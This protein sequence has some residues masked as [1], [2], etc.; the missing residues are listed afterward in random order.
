[1]ATHRHAWSRQI[2]QN[3]IDNG[4]LWPDYTVLVYWECYC[5]AHA[6]HTHTF[7]PPVESVQLEADSEQ[8]PDDACICATCRTHVNDDGTRPEE[9]SVIWPTWWEL[10]L[11]SDAPGS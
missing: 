5:G 6:T 8:E 11:P 3:N 2:E 9:T 1:M 7:S 4:G 10:K